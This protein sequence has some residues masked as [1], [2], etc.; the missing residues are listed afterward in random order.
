MDKPWLNQP[1][2]NPEPENQEELNL[3]GEDQPPNR[4][5]PDQGEPE[6]EESKKKWEEEDRV[7]E[8]YKEQMKK[9]EELW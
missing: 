2:A 8:E 4:L 6:S 9:L 3:T 1:G 7:L 5:D